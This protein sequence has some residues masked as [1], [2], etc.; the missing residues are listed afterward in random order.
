[1]PPLG[2][3]RLG[4]N[5]RGM[6]NRLLVS[7]TAALAGL[8][9][10]ED[11][12]KDPKV[13]VKKKAQLDAAT[14]APL[15]ILPPRTSVVPEAGRVWLPFRRGVFPGASVDELGLRFD[16]LTFRTGGEQW[17]VEPAR[18]E[19]GLGVSVDVGKRRGGSVLAFT[20][21]PRRVDI[22]S[23]EGRSETKLVSEHV[24]VC[25]H[26]R[27]GPWQPPQPSPAVAARFG[28]PLEI[29]V[30][31]DPLALLPGDEMQL[32][33]RFHA[34]VE[35]ALLIAEQIPNDGGGDPIEV[36]RG[37]VDKTGRAR[38]A[39]TRPGLWRVRTEIEEPAT[40]ERPAHLHRAM[41]VFR[42]GEK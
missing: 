24:K 19:D 2:R 41:I 1:M 27:E 21:V 26:L 29:A 18:G 7:L 40:E 8:T 6:R 30:S 9:A 32:R 5:T 16:Y 4:R 36:F 12:P 13:P 35:G 39:V 11:G 20:T 15:Y 34:P 10:C 23:P 25:M 14:V 33:V 22:A 37:P 31:S 38:I 42:T 17:V 28:F 3:S